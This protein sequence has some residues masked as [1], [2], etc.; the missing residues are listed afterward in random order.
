MNSKTGGVLKGKID[1]PDRTP[2]IY[3]STNLAKSAFDPFASLPRPG[4]H[5]TRARKDQPSR[6]GNFVGYAGG[7][8]RILLDPKPSANQSTRPTS[9]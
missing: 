1:D 3:D 6:R 8:A 5:I 2:L 7:N 4:R 9:R